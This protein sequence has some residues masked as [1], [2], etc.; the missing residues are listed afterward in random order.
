MILKNSMHTE[1]A[2]K[3]AEERTEF[4]KL[5]VNQLRNEILSCRTALID[6]DDT[7]GSDCRNG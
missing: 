3:I 6:P 1:T 4:M 5:F 2:K 7:L